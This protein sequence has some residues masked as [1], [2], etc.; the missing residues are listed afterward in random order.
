MAENCENWDRL[1]KQ[2][3]K[4]NYYQA[5]QAKKILVKYNLEIL[6]IG[7]ANGK[8]IKNLVK[9]VGEKVIEELAEIEHGRW[10]VEKLL[11]GW[12]YGPVRDNN[13][14]IHPLILPW[15]ILPES[16]KWKDR[17][18]FMNLPDILRKANLGIYRIAK[19]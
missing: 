3:Q 16:E 12:K 15:D 13:Q 2:Y 7:S 5:I 18:P 11:S 9:E 14:R 6:P 19:K 4:S 8:P 17:E 1:D 10:N